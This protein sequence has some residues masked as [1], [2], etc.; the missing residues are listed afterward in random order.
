MQA[1]YAHPYP[2]LD[3]ADHGEQIAPPTHHASACGPEP[4]V[5]IGGLV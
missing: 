3:L 1:L 4:T 2:I 5:R